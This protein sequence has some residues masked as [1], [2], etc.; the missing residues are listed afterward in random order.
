MTSLN[1]ILWSL[2][3]ALHLLLLTTL[4]LRG[5]ARRLP[6]F[7]GLLSFYLLRSLLLFGLSGQLKGPAYAVTYSVLS[8]LDLVL[9]T[10]VAW[11]LFCA[12]RRAAPGRERGTLLRRVTIFA[13][14]ALVAAGLAWTLSLSIHANPRTPI[15][16]GVLFTCLLMLAVAAASAGRRAELPAQR[17]LEGFCALSV[18]GILCQVER[19]L[20]GL[21]RNAALFQHWS[22]PTAM[23]YLIVLSFWLLSL[24]L[25]QQRTGIAAQPRE[26][27]TQA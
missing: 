1:T 26:L 24:Q 15:D 9:Q 16:R 25:L 17:A 12:A 23:M 13:G 18:T 20:A 3:I 8:S 14:C 5:I 27:A 7:T 22:Y 10:M 11:E 21:H 2:G 19:T 6:A 4:V